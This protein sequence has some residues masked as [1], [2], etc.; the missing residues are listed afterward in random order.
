MFANAYAQQATASGGDI[1][2]SLF[3]L[4]LIFAIFYFLI[5][6]P[7]NKRRQEHE[8]KVNA[9]VKNDQVITSGGMYGKV[10]NVDDTSVDVEIAR[11]VV[12]KVVK[13]TILDVVG[14]DAKADKTA[15]KAEKKTQSKTPAKKTKTKKAKK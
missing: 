7:Q 2:A 14:A 11:G 3:P 1:F 10:A 12:V 4:I 15:D 13:N 9:I 5:I 6:R 8:N